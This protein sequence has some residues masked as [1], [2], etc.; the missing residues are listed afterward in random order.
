[1]LGLFRKRVAVSDST[2][3]DDHGDRKDDYDEDGNEDAQIGFISRCD[4][5]QVV[6]VYN[7]QR[8]FLF[9]AVV[10]EHSATRILLG[11]PPAT[12]QLPLLTI[13]DTVF[14]QG[15]GKDFRTLEAAGT[16]HA[17]TKTSLAVWDLHQP[18]RPHRRAFYRQRVDNEAQL[19]K[20]SPRLSE[21]PIPC[22]LVDV[23]L[24]GASIRTNISLPMESVIRLRIELYPK[25][26]PISFKAQF[27]REMECNIDGMHHY[28]VLFE[29]LDSRRHHMLQ[30]DIKS[31]QERYYMH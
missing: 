1:M 22:T 16:I 24:E 11:R 13:G 4:N 3:T 25:A 7:A 12:M 30:E 6:D 31:F 28:G 20:T 26:G 15:C 17:S 5:G 14:L 23:S 21:T 27:V 8:A 29:Q 19:F 9:S 10:S 18:D 2:Q